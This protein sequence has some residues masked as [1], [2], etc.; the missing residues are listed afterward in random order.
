MRDNEKD[1]VSNCGGKMYYLSDVLSFDGDLKA[2]AI[3]QQVYNVYS[4]FLYSI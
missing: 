4:L 3:I 2:R 1:G